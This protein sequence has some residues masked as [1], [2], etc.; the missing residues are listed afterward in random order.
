M[1]LTVFCESGWKTVDF[2]FVAMNSIIAITSL[3]KDD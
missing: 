1:E 2:R 3:E